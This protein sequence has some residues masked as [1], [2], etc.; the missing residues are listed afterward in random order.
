MHCAD[1][2][3]KGVE[4]FFEKINLTKKAGSISIPYAGEYKIYFSLLKGLPKAF[5]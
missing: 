4:I 1:T 2:F 3:K 5:R